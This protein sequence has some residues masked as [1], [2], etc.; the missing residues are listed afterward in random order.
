M[1]KKHTD[2]Y[3]QSNERV[4]NCLKKVHETESLTL[5][6]VFSEGPKEGFSSIETMLPNIKF[7]F[8]LDT[9]TEMSFEHLVKADV[10]IVGRG[11]WAWS[12]AYLNEG[13][14][15]SYSEKHYDETII[16]C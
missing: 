16:E 12:V 7:E 8:H 6:H 4:V 14:R 2:G 13:K 11:N 3:F 1:R 15:Y 5:V 9:G 10:L